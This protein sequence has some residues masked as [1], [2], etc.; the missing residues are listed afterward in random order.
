MPGI[1][2]KQLHAIMAGYRVDDSTVA[3]E[4]RD[5]PAKRPSWGEHDGRYGMIG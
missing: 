5:T 2:Q 3:E 1:I 4:L